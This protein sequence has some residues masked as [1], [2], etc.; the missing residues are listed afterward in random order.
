MKHLINSK[1]FQFCKVGINRLICLF[2]GHEWIADWDNKYMKVPTQDILEDAEKFHKH[3]HTVALKCI[4]CGKA[5]E[6][7][8]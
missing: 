8:I 1:I 5:Q 3:F 4:R 2:R 7:T 6:E